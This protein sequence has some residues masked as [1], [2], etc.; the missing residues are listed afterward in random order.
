LRHGTTARWTHLIFGG[1]PIGDL[2]P[3]FGTYVAAWVT[4][5]RHL[6]DDVPRALALVGAGGL[7]GIA[8]GVVLVAQRLV[9]WPVAMVAGLVTV[10]DAGGNISNGSSAVFIFALYQ[11]ALAQAL[12]LVA[13]AAAIWSVQRPAAWRSL[14][15]WATAA[16]AMIAHRSA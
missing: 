7:I 1:E 3:S 16:L 9:R 11:H 13:I 5:A 15:V 2:Y 10:F 4:N 6:E 14:L 12:S 8:V